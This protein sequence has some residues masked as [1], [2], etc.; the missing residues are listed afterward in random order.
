VDRVDQTMRTRE[1]ERLRLEVE[2]GEERGF[3]GKNLTL[4]CHRRELFEPETNRG[5]RKTSAALGNA[6]SA[7]WVDE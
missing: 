5:V 4:R 2:R 1:A 3:V 7:H 6:N